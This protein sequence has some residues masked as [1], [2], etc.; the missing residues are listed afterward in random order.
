MDHKQPSDSFFQVKEPRRI[1]ENIKGSKFIASMKVVATENEAT[2][3]LDEIK[4]EF[5]DA[6]HNCFCWKIGAGRGQK[7]RY[8]DNG[9]PSGTAGLPIMKA[10]DGRRLSNICVVVTRYF[11]GVK[12]GTGGLMRAY[13]R[14]ATELLKDC[15]IEKKHFMENIK[16]SVS[17]DFVNVAH[18]VIGAF[19]AELKDSVY[20]DRVTF[21]VEVRSAHM[22]S[23][24]SK[25]TEATNGQIQFN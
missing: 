9:E 18:S 2:D 5:H 20:S 13:G 10:I 17:F 6:S 11:G 23:F 8:S 16:F 21:F 3:F 22:A 15:E 1:E 25:L 14:L 7:F 4:K 19:E 24:R 12:L